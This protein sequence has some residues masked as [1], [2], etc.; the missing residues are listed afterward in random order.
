MKF[1]LLAWLLLSL[2]GLGAQIAEELTE[3]DQPAAAESAWEEIYRYLRQQPLAIEARAKAAPSLSQFQA[4]AAYRVAKAEL[5]LHYNYRQK[6]HV[7]SGSFLLSTRSN[8]WDTAIGSYRFRFGRGLVSGS[9]SRSAADSLF[10]LLE[11]LSPQ[12]FSPQGA[13][14]VY[15]YRA[16]R[17]TCFGSLQDREAKIDAGG[18]IFSLPKTRSGAL[19][20]AQESIFGMAAGVALPRIQAGTLAYWRGYDRDF[21]ET[22]SSRSLW[23]GSVYAAWQHGNLRLDGEAALAGGDPSAF[24]GLGYRLGDFVQSLSYAHNGPKNQLPYSLTPALLSSAAARDELNYE[25]SLGLPF[26]TSLKLRYTLNSGPGFSGSQL[27]RFSGSLGYSHQGNILKLLVHSYDREIISLVDSS[28]VAADPRNLRL[29]LQ[30]RY[31]FMNHFTQNLEF[32]YTLTDRSDYS[33]NTY[34]VHLGFAYR[35]DHLE[36]GLAFQAWQSSRDLWQADELDPYSFELLGAE[37][38]LLVADLAWRSGPWRLSLSGRQ[39]LLQISSH[40]LWLRCGWT[41][42]G[43]A[44]SETA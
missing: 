26:H 2:A 14:L 44:G 32:S 22:G 30:G 25:L 1:G 3:L 35:R 11:P 39:S 4:S 43:R 24:L 42:P 29:Q 18:R 16:L 5:L 8:S 9:A 13:A 33:Q 27:S 37:D 6:D 20:T 34:R 19:S 40:Q 31:H 15:K 12:N 21:A 10:S 28:Y 23:A 17:A 36:L 38:R 41:W 7:S